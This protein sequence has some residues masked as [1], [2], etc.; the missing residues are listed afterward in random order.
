MATSRK[1]QELY[2]QVY[3]PR[4]QLKEAIRLLQLADPDDALDYDEKIKW[5]SDR[6]AIVKDVVYG[7][8]APKKKPTPQAKIQHP[9]LVEYVSRINSGRV[10]KLA[11]R[12][13]DLTRNDINV[14]DVQIE[15]D[16]ALVVN[17]TKANKVFMQKVINELGALKR[18]MIETGGKSFDR[19]AL[20]DYRDF[21]DEWKKFLSGPASA[22]NKINPSRQARFWTGASSEVRTA[23]MQSSLGRIT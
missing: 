2:D 15:T 18:M 20:K 12:S 9:S 4:V 3:T 8:N 7:R 14:I 13:Q 23:I 5:R 11:V 19:L 16:M 17:G 1:K 6:D 10:D 22:I 21:P